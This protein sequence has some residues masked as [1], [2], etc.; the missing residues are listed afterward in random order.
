MISGTRLKYSFTVWQKWWIFYNYN[1]LHWDYILIYFFQVDSTPECRRSEK[2]FPFCSTEPDHGHFQLPGNQCGVLVHV[3][4]TPIIEQHMHL[5]TG[6]YAHES[7]K[8]IF[9]YWNKGQ[10]PGRRGREFFSSVPSSYT[11]LLF[12]WLICSICI[13]CAHTFVP[14]KPSSSVSPTQAGERSLSGKLSGRTPGS[15]A[16]ERG[17][18]QGG[19]LHTLY[20]LLMPQSAAGVTAGVG[21]PAALERQS[22]GPARLWPLEPRLSFE[23]IPGAVLRASHLLTQFSPE[24]QKYIFVLS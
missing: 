12:P 16:L 10:I 2:C 8:I 9:L 18:G 11:V 5:L 14:A 23:G 24:T 20:F 4:W 6:P 7:R 22:C 15:S 21:L 1:F 17:C 13:S 3:S 19:S